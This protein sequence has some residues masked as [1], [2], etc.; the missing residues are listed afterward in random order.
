MTRA[1]LDVNAVANGGRLVTLD[2]TIA[3]DAVFRA[4]SEHVVEI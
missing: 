1:L 4:K 3:L 2:R